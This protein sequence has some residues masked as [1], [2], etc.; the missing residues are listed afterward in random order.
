MTREHDSS[1]EQ[2]Q[3]T[4]SQGVALS[5]TLKNHFLIAMPSMTDPQFSQSL[6]YICDH[7]EQGAMGVIINRKTDL[8]LKDV[9]ERMNIEFSNDLADTPIL[10]GGP[11]ST[12]RG[13]ILHPHTEDGSWQ[14]TV[15]LSDQVSLTA[16]KDIIDSLAVGSGPPHAQVALGYAGWGAGQL[17]TEIMENSW[18]TVPADSQILFHTP[19]EDRL[20]AAGKSLGIDINLLSSQSGNA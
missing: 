17:E 12:E 19:L 8:F 2:T 5:E 6:T 20:E 10:A 15:K 14:S 1:S 13:F 11:V 9:F 16:S 3:Q 4:G 18:L 7:N